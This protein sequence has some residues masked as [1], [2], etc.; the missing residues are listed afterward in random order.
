[1]EGMR[2]R[3]LPICGAAFSFEC[4]LGARCVVDEFVVADGFFEVGEQS[5]GFGGDDGDLGV[6]SGEFVDSVHGIPVSDDYELGAG[7]GFAPKKL[8]AAMA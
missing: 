4:L 2:Q 3:V 6:G 8:G 7:G 5:A 1:M